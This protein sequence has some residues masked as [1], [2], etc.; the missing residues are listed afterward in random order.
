MLIIFSAF[1]S[2]Q[3]VPEWTCMSPRHANWSCQVCFHSGL[4]TLRHFDPIAAGLFAPP[5]QTNGISKQSMLQA[6]KHKLAA[7]SLLLSKRLIR[8]CLAANSLLFAK[9]A[10]WICKSR[11]GY[12]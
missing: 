9:V 2:Q 6:Q 3:M 4:I 12:V 11:T 1:D 5:S 10:S 7:S 8:L